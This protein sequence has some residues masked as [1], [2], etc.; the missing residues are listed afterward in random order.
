MIPNKFLYKNIKINYYLSNKK[1]NKLIFSSITNNII[2]CNLNYYKY[3]DYIANICENNY[4]NDLYAIIVDIWIKKNYLYN[5]YIYNNIG[6]K[7]QSQIL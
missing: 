2:D 5:N 6:D 4:K 3:L 1:H 7:K